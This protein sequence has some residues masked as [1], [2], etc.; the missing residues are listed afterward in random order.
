METQTTQQQPWCWVETNVFFWKA[1]L[2]LEPSRPLF[3]GLKPQQTEMQR[4]FRFQEPDFRG[5]ILEGFALLNY[6][7]AGG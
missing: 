6:Y 5:V 2:K 4:S 3:H 7:F 1:L